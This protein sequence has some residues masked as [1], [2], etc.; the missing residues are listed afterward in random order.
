MSQGRYLALEGTE[1]VGKTTLNALLA[2]RL[3]ERG[4]EVV[5]VREPGG[6]PLGEQIRAMLLH[7][8]DMAGWTEALLFAA[9]RSELID[10]VVRPALSRGCWVLSDRCYHSSLAYQGAARGLGVERVWSVNAP[11][12]DGV[13]PDLVLWLDQDHRV[14]L[15]RQEG[16]DRIGGS[17]A[18]LHREVRRGYRRLWALERG[19]MLR[20]DATETPERTSDLVMEVLGK[21]GWL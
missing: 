11:A 13:L 6:T 17:D 9:Q 18:S 3:G 10:K 1:G 5:R 8:R 20:V 12:L 4:L 21:R 14:G 2:D 16:R 7:G 19:R 15:V